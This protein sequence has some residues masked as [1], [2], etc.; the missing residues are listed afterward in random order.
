MNH[1]PG[2]DAKDVVVVGAW[3]ERR[4]VQ[5]P[6]TSWKGWR[7]PKIGAASPSADPP[8]H[9]HSAPSLRLQH[10]LVFNPHCISPSSRLGLAFD[11]STHGFL[12][13]LIITNRHGPVRPDF[14]VASFSSDFE[15]SEKRKQTEYTTPP[16]YASHHFLGS[17]NITLLRIQNQ[18][19][20]NPDGCHCLNIRLNICPQRTS[21]PFL[22]ALS[23]WPP[24]CLSVPSILLES[25]PT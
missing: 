10:S 11:S 20:R 4:A 25:T 21:G 14:L 19:F 13:P 2:R 8:K 15:Y 17:S 7:Q 12:L 5:P 24:E 1:H 18:I 6:N 9:R 16:S 23:R 22:D 3:Q